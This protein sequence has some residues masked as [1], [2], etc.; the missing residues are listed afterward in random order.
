MAFSVERNN[1][2][3]GAAV[4]CE[5]VK[6]KTGKGLLYAGDWAKTGALKYYSGGMIY[7]KEVEI[8][9]VNENERILLDLGNVVAS[10]E[11][12]VNGK[13][14]GI[15]MSP[16]YEVDITSYVT[17]GNNNIEVLVYSTLSNHYQTIPSPYRGEPEAGML[18]PV[19]LQVHSK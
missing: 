4:V 17:F 5:P 1:G 3:Q 13:Q 14:V 6:L 12:K 7:R 19:Q 9:S 2:Y 10:C 11:I 18:G 8:S 15:C 16:P